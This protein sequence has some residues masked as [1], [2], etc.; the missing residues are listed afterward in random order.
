MAHDSDAH[1]AYRTLIEGA[2]VRLLASRSHVV[3]SDRHRDRFLHNMTTCTV[4][5]IPAGQGAFGL[6]VDR[7]GKLVGQLFLDVETD[8]IRVEVDGAQR[9]SIVAHWLAHRVADMIRF[10]DLDGLAVVNLAGPKALSILEGLSLDGVGE[11]PNHAWVEVEISG[12]ACRL[13]R[14]D[15]RLALPAFDLTLPEAAAPEL[16]SVLCEAGASELSDEIWTAYRILSGV[17]K[18]RVDMT[19]ENIPL[20]SDHLTQGISWDK[21]CYIGQEVIAR[22]HYRGNPNRHLRGLL[23]RGGTP[24]RG[25]GLVSI[26]GKEAGVIGSVG[27][28]PRSGDVIA[29]AVVKRKMAEAGTALK[30]RSGVDAEVVELP[31]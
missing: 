22:M 6:T 10:D 24:E 23:I 18:E 12:I 26:E 9:E 28:D 3:A 4:K 14:N 21:G 19:G 7:G 20:E 5:G 15:D 11:L 2:A 29:L 31:F 17:P 27:V 30:T 1:V 16:L 13:R 8:V 25:E